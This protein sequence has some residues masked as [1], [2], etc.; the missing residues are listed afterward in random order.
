MRVVFTIDQNAEIQLAVALAGIRLSGGL[1]PPVTVIETGALDAGSRE[2]LRQ[3]YPSIEFKRW[4]PAA[5]FMSVP[6]RGPRA[7]YARLFLA[8]LLPDEDL[9]LYLDSDILVCESLEDLLAR[10]PEF[11]GMN[12]IAACVDYNPTVSARFAEGN[13]IHPLW[14]TDGNLDTDSFF[15][16][17]VL[18]MSLAKLRE[19][20][21]I[22]TFRRILEKHAADCPTFDQNVI[23]SAFRG[24]ISHLP[25]RWN[26]YHLTNPV[27]SA[28][29]IHF[30]TWRK[31]TTPLFSCPTDSRFNALHWHA[32]HAP[33]RWYRLWFAHLDSTP[34]RGWRPWPAG[35]GPLV[36]W[37]LRKLAPFRA[38]L[39]RRT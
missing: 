33:A 3:I 17:G 30:I 24:R 4:E 31:P 26:R 15:N 39:M 28:S 14:R 9:V 37:M 12:S 7:V 21:S 29:I 23:N 2:A 20:D 35:V 11:L 8:D 18:L 38:R 25:P 34:F 36:I 19:E 32:K 6:T 10:A 16:T 5:W 22:S 1:N 13:E 27:D